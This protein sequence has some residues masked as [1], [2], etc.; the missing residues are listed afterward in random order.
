M[1]STV[2]GRN[3]G[4]PAGAVW[5]FSSPRAFSAARP[6]FSL[7]GHPD[8]LRVLHPDCEH[9]FPTEMRETAYALFDSVL[10]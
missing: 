6:I 3:S 4:S 2:V 9:D 10:R 7:Y 8:R 1:L 5:P